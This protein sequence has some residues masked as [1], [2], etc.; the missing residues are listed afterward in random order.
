MIMKK[1]TYEGYTYVDGGVCAAKGFVANGINCGLNSDKNKNDLGMVYSSTV[2]NA[3]AVYTQNKVKGAPILVTKEHLKATGG[4]A[5][6][7]VVNSKNANTCNADGVEKAER[8]CELAADALG[9]DADMIIN[10]STGVIGQIIPIEPFEEH[11]KE[12]A[13]GLSAD[14]NDKAANA[15]MTTDTVDKQVAVEFTLGGKTCRLGGM[16]KG[17]GMIHPNMATTLNFIT[18]DVAISADMIQKAL[19]EIVKVTYNCLSIDGD[20]STNDTLS[21]M[22]NGLAGNEEIVTENDDYAIFKKVLYIVME[23]MTMMLASDG[24]GA[25]KML[26]CTVSGAPDQDTAI[27]VAKSII[28]S[29][30]TKCAMF[31]EDANWGRILCAI[32]YAEADFDI[33]KVDVDL[34]SE[35]GIVEV[36]RN[37][38]GIPFSEEKAS[39]VLS[40]D[41][42]YI[43]VNLNQGEA[44]AK[45]WGCDLTYDY[46]KINGDYRS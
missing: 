4:K 31:G 15:I 7:V 36:C 18:T 2:C 30:L 35:K 9:I 1:K 11:M 46:V 21:V 17:S 26:E 41:D 14:G 28:R 33:D 38:S 32:G 45:A 12:L 6:A 16:A 8:I 42:I 34:E 20:T 40:E 5:M 19:S 44:S 3:A 24:E 37:G 10:A 27:I 13:G 39:E 43:N 22:A 23:C 25:S 29:P